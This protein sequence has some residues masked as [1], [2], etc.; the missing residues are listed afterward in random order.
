[1]VENKA[2]IKG[3]S[4]KQFIK[5]FLL[6]SFLLAIILVLYLLL[7]VAVLGWADGRPV[8]R[9]EYYQRLESMY[10]QGLKQKLVTS[11]LLQSEAKK[12]QVSVSDEEVAERVKQT[13]NYYGGKEQFE[14]S[15]AQSGQTREEYIKGT[16]ELLLVDAIFGKEIKITDQELLEYAQ[17]NKERLGGDETINLLSK[18]GTESAQLKGQLTIQLK[19][20]KISE[21]YQEWI[22]TVR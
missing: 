18:E 8:T 10:G 2:V 5:G 20:Q 7:R 17:K 22:K 13:E 1:M 15:L 4:A 6:M 12:R 3:F 11:L 9:L 16:K 21:A 19:E 14:Q